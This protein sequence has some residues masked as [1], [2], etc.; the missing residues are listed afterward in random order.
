M[1]EGHNNSVLLIG[2]HGA[3]KTLA[4][5]RAMGIVSQKYNRDA[6]D[7]LVGVV[8][9]LGW[10]HSDERT[11][12]REIARQLCRSFQLQFAKGASVGNN[13]TFL[14]DVLSA[15]AAAHKVAVFVLDGLD[16]FAK[17]SKQTLLYCLLDALQTSGAQAVVLGLTTRHDC[18]ELLE[19]RVKSR[20]SHR[21]AL[22]HPPRCAVATLTDKLDVGN[23]PGPSSP[24]GADCPG[25]NKLQEGS[26]DVLRYMLMLPAGF[27]HKDHASRHN[28]AVEAALAHASTL[29]ALDAYVAARPCLHNLR[30]VALWIIQRSALAAGGVP[31]I[32]AVSQACAA[33]TAALDGG[34]ERYIEGLSVLEVMVLVAAF[35]ASDRRDGDAITFEMMLNE[36][37]VYCSAGEHV[38]NYSKVA[39]LKAFERIVGMGLLT[40][41]GGARGAQSAQGTRLSHHMAVNLQVRKT[42]LMA[43]LAAHGTCPTRLRDWAVREGGP[44]TTA[45]AMI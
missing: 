18:L 23:S 38:D 3:G 2:S 5:E 17:R 12:F 25:S 19:K 15:L 37:T 20:F 36:F 32:T 42:E 35:R 21:T 9:L 27:P 39:A 28:A 11:A 31:T 14:R 13:I 16:L 6:S 24:S 43:G 29:P 26:I 1:T 4:V 33:I 8:R 7:P 40:V 30:N 45:A 44:V 34:I 10:A 41:A 22:V